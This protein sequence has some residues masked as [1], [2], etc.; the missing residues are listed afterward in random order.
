MSERDAYL[1]LRQKVITSCTAAARDAAQVLG[2][3]ECERVEL[4]DQQVR[5]VGR[6]IPSSAS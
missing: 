1:V 3:R 2:E 5:R 4:A 6:K